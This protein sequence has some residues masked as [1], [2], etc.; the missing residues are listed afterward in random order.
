[1]SWWDTVDPDAHRDELLDRGATEED[2]D[3]ARDEI[4]RRQGER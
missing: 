1:M 4:L 3:A 2:A